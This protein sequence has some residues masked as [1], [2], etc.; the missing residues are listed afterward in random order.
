M[1][2]L[3]HAWA[4]APAAL[5][6]CCLAADRRRVRAPELAASVLMLLAMLDA[7]RAQPAVPAVVWAAIL[8]VAAM[9]VAA[10]RRRRGAMRMDAGAMPSTGMTLH[11]TLGLVVMAVLVAMMTPHS[12]GVAHHGPSLGAFIVGA[13][14][15][16]AAYAAASVVAAARAPRG[17]PLD[18]MQYAAM[19]ISALF[20]AL[21]LIA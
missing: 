7:T 6:T 14:I 9:A 1:N 8:L 16:A 3:L 12:G 2:E 17:R 18:R 5:G 15:A 20:M 19:G 13:G 11:T 21:P 10:V 4:L